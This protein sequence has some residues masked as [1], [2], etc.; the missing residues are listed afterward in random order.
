MEG[1]AVAPI[2]KRPMRGRA[3][4]GGGLWGTKVLVGLTILVVLLPIAWLV[5]TS[6]RYTRQIMA[7]RL[8]TGMTFANF[9]ALLSPGSSFLA[10]CRNS[11]MITLM[12][13]GLVLVIG[14]LAAYS[15]SKYRW[16]GWFVIMMMGWGIVINMLP[17]IAL[18][19]A[20]Y[21][22]ARAS[23]LYNT[24]WILVAVYT[25]F[26]TP[27]ALVMLKVGFDAVPKELVEA[28]QIDG[29]PDIMTFWRVVLPLA[30]P[31][32]VAAGFLT[33]IMC[34]DDFILALS[35]TATSAAMTIPVGLSQFVQQY[36]ISYGPMASG[37]VI[38]IAPVLVIVIFAQRY[39][40]KGLTGGAIKG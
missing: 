1:P 13:T 15:L 19:P 38:A 3:A 33:A 36:D 20:L 40:V 23:A 14:S 11:I 9:H 22:I 26:N 35:L 2:V 30:V 25:F 18:V 21:A 12:S 29:S 5:L 31:S 16:R 8:V 28:A 17:Q 32:I 39:L 10:L 24:P 4:L 34:W 7:N 6:L 27:L 37:T